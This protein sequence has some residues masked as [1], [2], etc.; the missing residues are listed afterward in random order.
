MPAA[1]RTLTR[2]GLID[3]WIEVLYRPALTLPPDEPDNGPIEIEGAGVLVQ[4][5]F[6]IRLS[7]RARAVWQLSCNTGGSGDPECA[8]IREGA[9]V[10]TAPSLTV[11]GEVFVFPGDG[12]LYSSSRTNSAFDVRRKFCERGGILEEVPQP[13]RYVG[14]RSEA[15]RDL[16]IFA[17]RGLA[18]PSAII[19]KGAAIEI[20]IE[21]RGLFL[22]RDEFGLT[23]WIKP[24]FE[25]VGTHI[26]GLDFRGD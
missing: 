2:K 6:K 9:P 22:V 17:D 1:F 3:D 13:M 10:A 12:C 25:Q 11:A 4:S 8:L 24:P 15:L 5:P 16:R 7:R 18:R 23:G 21:D 26:K 19:A 14:L 20:L